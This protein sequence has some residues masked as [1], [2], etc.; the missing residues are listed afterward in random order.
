MSLKVPRIL[1]TFTII[2]F[3]RPLNSKE[4][5]QGSFGVVETGDREIHI[6]DRTV[7]TAPTKTFSFDK[8]YGQHSKQIEVYKQV[9]SPIVDE[10]LSGYNCT[11]FA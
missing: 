11:V 2:F 10:V 9:V 7:P 4:K 8:V 6:K 5:R 3:S 1:P